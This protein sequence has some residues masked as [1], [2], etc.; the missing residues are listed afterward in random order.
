MGV[1]EAAGSSDLV[2]GG[3]DSP[4]PRGDHLCFQKIKPGPFRRKTRAGG[5]HSS[6]GEEILNWR[7]QG[8][9][10]SPAAAVPSYHGLS[11]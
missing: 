3:S 8:Q 9:R 4:A 11:A 10:E 5:G 1:A 7:P 6:R 2:I